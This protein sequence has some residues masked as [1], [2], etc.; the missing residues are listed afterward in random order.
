MP[1]R[2][3]SAT[4]ACAGSPGEIIAAQVREIAEMRALL[5]DIAANRKRGRTPLPP[6]A[7]EVTPDMLP[8]IRA[9]VE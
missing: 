4:R 1:A 2:P 8:E 3:A 7:A 9:A 5:A 6:Q